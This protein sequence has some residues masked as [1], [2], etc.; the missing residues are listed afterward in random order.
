M[1]YLGTPVDQGLVVGY[2][3]SDATIPGEVSLID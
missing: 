2:Y 1:R 3:E